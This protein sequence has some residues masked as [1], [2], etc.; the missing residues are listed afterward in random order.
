MSTPT[1]DSQFRA[2]R[3]VL[4]LL[5]FLS[6]A[7]GLVYEVLWLKELGLLF[8]NTAYAAATTL[9]VFFLGMATG[10]WVFGRRAERLARPL[11][12][13]AWLE[14]G[15]AGSAL[16]FFLLTPAFRWI[17]TLLFPAIGGN[18][19]LGT[20]VKFLLALGVLFLPAFFMGGTLPVM[21]Q[22]LIRRTSQLGRTGTLLYLTNTSGAAVGALLAGFA[23][24]PLLGFQRSYLLAICLSG[25]V[26]LVAW[27][28]GNRAPE[29]APLETRD[30]E[31]PDPVDGTTSIRTLAF[32]SGFLVLGLEVL[33]TRMFAQVL[34][35][36]VYS[37][38]AILVTF[39]V[40]LAIGSAVANFL[41]RW[42]ALTPNRVLV[43]LA[44]VSWLLVA[45][46]IRIF[47]SL[48]GG[49]TEFTGG[50][51]WEGYLLRIFGLAA[52]VMLIPG[53]IVGSIYPYLLKA[54]ESLRR[55]P[56]KTIGYLAA[57]NSVGGILGSLVAGFVLLGITGLW[58]GVLWMAAGYL[59]VAV[60]AGLGNRRHP[61]V[62]AGIAAVAVLVGFTLPRIGLPEL[63]IVHVDQNAGEYLIET[64]EGRHGTVA[65]IGVGDN[66]FIKVD[67]HYSLG[68]V[69]A[70]D[71]ERRQ[72][73]I[74]MFVIAEPKSVFFLGMGTGITAGGALDFPV[75]RV[76]TCELL[77]EVVTAAQ[78]HFTQWTN[79]LF[80]D[81][82]SV[83]VVEDGRHFLTGTRERFD[84]VISD[85]FIP[86]HAGTG[87]LYTREHFEICRSR[88]TD[89]GH[90]VQWIPAHQLS[91]DE[92]DVIARTL[93][94]VFP[95]VTVWR[96][97][98]VPQ[99]PTLGF[100]C[101]LEEWS[102]DP[103]L[104]RKNLARVIPERAS[105]RITESDV[106]PYLM[107]AGNLGANRAL[108]E[109]VSLNTDDRPI[110]EYASPKTEQRA[111]SGETSWLSSDSLLKLLDDL[112][113][114]APP[115][116]DPFLARLTP[117]Q[118]EYVRAGKMLYEVGVHVRAERI[119][120][121]APLYREFLAVVPFDIFPGL[122]SQ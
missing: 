58:S 22:H 19:A 5:F 38:T 67:N 50:D 77:P 55:A 109:G 48:T 49:L 89:G 33:W 36:S 9:A 66:R 27:R 100:I 111:I 45:A 51:G 76:V 107:Y 20:L 73:Q 108:F 42:R 106:L 37:F 54:S 59:A 47:V 80:T 17:Y 102:L 69:A 31:S 99:L 101:G 103:E 118:I 85:L 7:A 40:A 28:M 81:P 116:K 75:E 119:D 24:P 29:N 117:S 2:E 6:G 25:L 74:P 79:G 13:Y 104:A 12:T 41:C 8:G 96:G 43:I 71:S 4:F 122:A 23:L 82:R 78:Q 56:G 35:N 18:L 30:D 44:V 95:Y 32:L 87:S 91:R 72:T 121:A 84:V 94:E 3:P 26:G 97:E 114:G 64:W 46:S 68:D 110:I 1:T 70:F 62:V 57:T 52:A 65:V 90:F 113:A 63:P 21:G 60:I 115:E 11:R 15:I 34:H 10:G 14:L 112:T 16:L 61:A 53:V 93:L 105:D 83:V 120:L 86:W 92:F 98:F 39:L 88:L